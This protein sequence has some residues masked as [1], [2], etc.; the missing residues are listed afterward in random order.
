MAEI[1]TS[2]D[3]SRTTPEAPGIAGA[4]SRGSTASGVTGPFGELDMADLRH[5]TE[6]S[7][8]ALALS[9]VALAAA[10][11]VFVLVSLG[12]ATVLETVLRWAKRPA[13]T[14]PPDRSDRANGP[15]R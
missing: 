9:A 13:P 12:Q 14:P 11:A 2:G 15:S 4:E 5:P 7:R 3:G 1:D 6:P 8:F 10:L